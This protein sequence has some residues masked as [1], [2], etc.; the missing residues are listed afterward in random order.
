[1]YF[2]LMEDRIILRMSVLVAVHFSNS[3]L[4]WL[5]RRILSW[6]RKEYTSFCAAEVRANKVGSYGTLPGSGGVG[7]A[8][9]L[10]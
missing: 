10:R 5:N 1:M 6:M 4:R 3:I 9:L 8:S 2:S 7:N